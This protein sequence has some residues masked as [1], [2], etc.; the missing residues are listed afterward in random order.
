MYYLVILGL[1]LV[2]TWYIFKFARGKWYDAEADE[3]KFRVKETKEIYES[4]KDVNTDRVK[5]QHDRIEEIKEAT[6]L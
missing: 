2:S 4:V 6:D 1:A 5:K 3:V